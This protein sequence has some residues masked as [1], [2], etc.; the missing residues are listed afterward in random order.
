M[1]IDFHQVQ[2]QKFMALATQV[3]ANRNTITV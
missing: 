2:L 3:E 1:L